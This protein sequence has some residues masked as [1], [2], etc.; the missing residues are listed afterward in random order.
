MSFIADAVATVI[1]IVIKVSRQEGWGEE[2]GHH[3][4]PK[5]TAPL[6]RVLSLLSLRWIW[7]P[8]SEGSGG[9][10]AVLW[11]CTRCLS[12]WPQPG[13]LC[14]TTSMPPLSLA[15]PFSH[16]PIPPD[17]KP[18]PP[19][20]QPLLCLNPKTL[21]ATQKPCGDV[22]MVWLSPAPPH[23]WGYSCSPQAGPWI[24]WGTKPLCYALMGDFH[25]DKLCRP[26]LYS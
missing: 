8:C 19:A 11:V 13:S 21:L 24:E 9:P 20:L 7:F 25:K 14:P 15:A 1:Q 23:G 6:E 22:M 26:L 3:M 4:T 16:P 10:P 17:V 2:D 5:P 12:S 18:E